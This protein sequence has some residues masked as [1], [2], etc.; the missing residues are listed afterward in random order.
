MLCGAVN[1]AQE[2]RKS[3][4]APEM[5]MFVAIFLFGGGGGLENIGWQCSD[6]LEG[7]VSVQDQ[8]SPRCG[9]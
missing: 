4:H 8:S 9:T 5:E 6:L 3:W 1:G 7:G 2:W